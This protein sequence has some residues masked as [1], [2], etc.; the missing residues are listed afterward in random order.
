MRMWLIGPSVVLAGVSCLFYSTPGQTGERAS[1][2]RGR[3]AVHS[4][5]QPVAF[6]RRAYDDAWKHWGVSAK[7]ANYEQA[8]RDRY[9]LHA[10]PYA[11]KDL[12]MGFHE[13][14]RSFLGK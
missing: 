5:L 9:G 12:P 4:A 1:A 2:E 6:S 11:N 10:A 14:R 7:P 3:D 8:F 13:G